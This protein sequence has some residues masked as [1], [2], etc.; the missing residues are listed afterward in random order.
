M[1]DTIIAWLVRTSLRIPRAVVVLALALSVGAGAFAANH[2]AIDTD[3][4]KL[5]SAEL[6]WRKRE[7][8]FDS[9]FPQNIDLLAIVID[10]TTPELAERATAALT[11]K[12]RTRPDLFKTVRRPDGGPFFDRNGLLYLSVDEVQA[13]TEQIVAAQPLLGPLVADPTLRGLFNALSTFVDGISRGAASIDVIENPMAEI[14]ASLEAATKGEIR[15]PS[16]RQ[17]FT[18]QLPRPQELRRFIL[19]QPVLDF[20]SVT[21]GANAAEA[22]RTMA[23]ELSIDLA[24][25]ARVR[26]T[27]PVALSDDEFGTLADGMSISGAL[28]VL[29]VGVLLFVG[30]GSIKLIGAIL[31]TLTVGL[32]LTAGFATLAIGSLNLIS[33][34]FAVLFWG[35]AV[36][37]GIQVS[38]AFRQARFE[39]GSTDQALMRALHNI[40]TALG[41][42][43]ITTA[44]GFFSLLPTDYR[45]VS[46]LGLIAGAGMIIALIL[47]VTLLPALLK[48]FEPRGEPE[49]VG[50][51]GLAPLDRLLLNHRRIV[52]G[53]ALVLAIASGLACMKLEFDFNPLN[54]KDQRTESVATLLDLMKEPTTTPN[55]I[56]VLTASVDDADR[57]A[58]RL[59]QLP[60]VAHAVSLRSYVPENQDEKLAFI[61]DARLLLAPTFN[62]QP[63]LPPP[64]DAALLLAFRTLHDRLE[65][66]PGDNKA[67]MRLKQAL[68]QL[69]NGPADHRAIAQEALVPGLVATLTQLRTALEAQTVSFETLPPELHDAWISADG[70]SRVELFPAGDANDNDVLRQFVQVVRAIA[71]DA[72]G[73]PVSIQES[74][75]TVVNAFVTAGILALVAISIL[76]LLILRSVR[77]VAIVIAP[78]MLAGLMTLGTCV[79]VGLPLNFANIIALPLLFG[80]G[81]A[82]NIYFVMAWRQGHDHLLQSSLT[83]AIIFSA[84]STASAFGSLAVSS[85][86][87]TAEMGILL[88]M[89]LFFT[90]LTTMLVLPSLLGPARR[91]VAP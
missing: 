74:S 12:L 24:H 54:I 21:P 4:T 68:A 65:Q 88:S 25:G 29:A 44:V 40:G 80:I 38:V 85:H 36:D 57:L 19:T 72:T 83:R 86:P 28:S 73:T 41:L 61:E 87:G 49:S 45:G 77:D 42:A 37:F 6:P 79:V 90:L 31:L 13:T 33:I 70:K 67:I 30:L 32:I 9:A 84:A 63:N 64:D 47:N 5:L 55:T 69:I 75:R 53:I 39:L 22:V 51:A 17:M 91:A 20:T 11:A 8:V 2:L 56:D 76:L 27:G 81:V 66:L 1:F 10:G 82:F 78:L 34:A 3:A 48:I 71:P 60:E 26:L 18:N 46:E 62:A 35:I 15:A 7:A 16:W 89:S 50:Y 58:E 59:G 14:A 23:H 43:A 52:L